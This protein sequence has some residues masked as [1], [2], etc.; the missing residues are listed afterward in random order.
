MKITFTFT[1]ILMLIT[2]KMLA[3]V[4]LKPQPGFNPKIEIAAIYIEYDDQILILHRQNT[5]SEGNKWGIPGGKIDKEETPLQAIIRE[6]KEETGFDI[7]KQSIETLKAV[8]IE[9]DQ[10]NHIV[11][12]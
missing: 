3:T 4:Y 12:H 10:K 2:T 5:K 8:Y 6:T 1:F 7:S 11:Y 9:Y